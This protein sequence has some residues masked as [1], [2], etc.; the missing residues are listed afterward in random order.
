MEV[1]AGFAAFE[2][3]EG[4]IKVRVSVSSNEDAREV[5]DASCAGVGAEAGGKVDMDVYHCAMGGATK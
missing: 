2:E 4:V 3:L 5:R 1:E